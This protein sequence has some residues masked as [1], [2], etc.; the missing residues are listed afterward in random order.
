MGKFN[1]NDLLSAASLQASNVEQPNQAEPG[2]RVKLQYISAY[3]LVASEDNFY[4]ITE[5]NELKTAIELAGKVMQNLTVIPLPNGKYKVISGHRRRLAVLSLLEEG[6]TQYEF[7]PCGIESADQEEA[8]IRGL[9]E[10]LLLIVAN[11]QRVKTDW[12]KIEEVGRMHELLERLGRTQK[13]PGRKREIIAQA[14]HTS[15]AQIGRID[16]IRK[17][18]SP[19]LTQE[20]KDQR[21]NLSTAYELSGLSPEEQQAAFKEHRQK[22]KIT[23]HDAKQKKRPAKKKKPEPAQRIHELKILPNLFEA[24]LRGLK[25]WE[26][27]KNDRQFAKG[28]LMIEREY[29]PVSGCFTGRSITEEIVFILQGGQYGIPTDYVIMTTREIKKRGERDEL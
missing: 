11:S 9:R 16:A 15:S 27:R 7:V 28:D 17:H 29:E 19:E 12:D 4:S 6:K 24:K 20:L 13:L 21:I 8:E 25:P 18:L 23:L 1:L 10:Q 26:Y 5:I 14:L 22:G 2:E 3:D